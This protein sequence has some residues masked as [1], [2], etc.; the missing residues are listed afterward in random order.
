MCPVCEAGTLCNKGIRYRRRGGNYRSARGRDWKTC[1]TAYLTGI[2]RL[3]QS[4]AS[5]LNSRPFRLVGYQIHTAAAVFCQYS[6]RRLDVKQFELGVRHWRECQRVLGNNGPISPKSAVPC[7]EC[8]ESCCVFLNA[9]TH[10][11]KT[12]SY[13]L[14]TYVSR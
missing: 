8:S 11:H 13:H 1:L 4:S 7:A 9:E 12:V 2:R 5:L 6:D 10:L 3:R 14:N